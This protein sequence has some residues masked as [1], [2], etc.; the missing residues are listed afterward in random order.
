MPGLFHATQHVS[1]PINRA[2]RN[3][4]EKS[5]T[6]AGTIVDDGISTDKHTNQLFE[7]V[8]QRKYPNSK[9]AIQI[10]VCQPEVT[11]AD[12]AYFDQHGYW[13][14]PEPILD[15]RSV[16]QLR[17]DYDDIFSGTLHYDAST[18]PAWLA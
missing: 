14:A 13:L 10:R 6:A 9:S 12:V 5:G 17:R 4:C 16:A 7:R 2:H 15:E 11:D 8:L 3:F 18:L 1:V